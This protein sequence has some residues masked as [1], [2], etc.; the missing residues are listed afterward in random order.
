MPAAQV[1]R[2][3]RR[4][5]PVF[6][7]VLF[8]LAFAC[9]ALGLSGSAFADAS[10]PTTSTTL[11][12]TP[13]LAGVGDTLTMTATVTGVGANPPGSVTFA[14]GSTPIATVPATPVAGSTTTSQAVL[15]TSSLAAGTYAVTATFNSSDVFDFDNSTSDPVTLTVSGVQIFNTT[16]TL[17]ASP[18]SVTSGQALTLT[19]TVAQ[20]GG[21]GIPTGIVTFRDNGVLLGQSTL[22][23]TGT[24]TLTRSDYIAGQHT[25]EADYSGDMVDRA[26]G[27][28]IVIQVGGGSQ[29]V[30]TTTTVTATPNPIDAGGSLTLTAHVVRTQGGTPAPAGGLVT[31]RTIGASGAFLGEAP[32]DAN[33][34]ATIT[35]GGWIV[36][37]YTIEA[38]YEG[39]TF[40]LSSSGQVVVGVQPPG[41]D[42]SV[43]AA[44]A[45]ATAHTGGQITYTLAVANAG[46]DPAQNV[47]LTDALPAGTTFVSA[48]PG[49]PACTVASAVLTCA[50]GTMAKGAQQ[51]VTLVVAV[52][53]GLAGTTVSDTAQVTSDTA[54][55]NA[56]NNASTVTTPVRAAADLKL[57]MTGPSSVLAGSPVAYTL[58]VANAGPDAAAS[59]AVTDTLPSALTGATA[60]TTAG[61]CSVVSAAVSCTVASLGAGA[62]FTITV[63]ATV[64]ATTTATS[65][66]NTASVTSAT[67]DLV[68][69]NNSA[70]VVTSVTPASTCSTEGNVYA[71]QD[72]KQVVGRKTQIVHVD[73]N[74]DCDRDRKTGTVFLH[75]G[76][77]RVTIDGHVL[78]DA[79]QRDITQVRFI[80]RNDAV[81]TG[82][83]QGTPFTVT[84]HDG[85]GCSNRQ[86]SVRV[87]YGSFDTATL[88]AKHGEVHISTR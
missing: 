48:A 67:D 2:T 65:I 36:G 31:F 63:N 51:T 22:D 10:D 54:D 21:A 55:P 15:V 9:A 71:N 6:L 16:T 50:L 78:I 3:R 75:H 41:A 19:A 61:S 76:S 77:V 18:P 73:A 49:S 17:T 34:N 28:T 84:L 14:N 87:Q 52:G 59:V 80:G 56:A 79:Q 38:D 58:T 37:T 11:V 74:A 72:F 68:A 5:A 83:W 7:T 25:I 39:D 86:D 8:G 32:L 26:S 42:L 35:V 64:S 60:T 47:R 12:V 45:P 40:D 44:A 69:S 20:V 27:A 29:A 24:A 46:L 62:S 70:T 88:Q 66:S 13:T 53:P 4:R 1:S 23:A 82:T 81:I 30:S 57:T 33:G 43:T 85:G